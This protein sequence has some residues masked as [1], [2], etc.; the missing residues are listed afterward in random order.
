[1][2][3]IAAP[4]TYSSYSGLGRLR[5]IWPAVLLFVCM[6][7]PPEVA[8]YAGPLRVGVYRMCLMA[9]SPIIIFGI[10]N[11]RYKPHIL[12]LAVILI[13]MWLPLSFAVN[14]DWLVGLE[15]GGSQSLD[16]LL[17]YFIARV[18]IRTLADFRNFLICIFPA[19]MFVGLLLAMESLSGQLFVR[20]TAQSIF[21]GTGD[22]GNRLRAEFREGFLR[23]YSVFTHPIHA[24]LFLS[25]FISLYFMNFR[26]GQWRY[27]GFLVGI[28]GFFSLS[29]AALLGI[30]ANFA[31]L[32][33]DWLQQR[34]K[35]LNWALFLTTTTILIATVQLFSQNGVVPVIYRYLTFNAQTGYYRT[36]IWQYAGSEA[37]AHPWFGIGYEEY[38]RPEWMGRASID[39]HYLFMATSYGFVPAFAYFLVSI[40]VIILLGRCASHSLTS[41]S[42]R[43]FL[44]LAASLSVIVIL[45]FTVTFWGAM[46][47]WFNFT[48][49]IGVAL[50]TWSANLSDGKK[51]VRTGLTKTPSA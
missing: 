50:T 15:A 30:A 17:S 31:I 37:L 24:G 1:M 16:M 9:L 34:V 25:S 13:A 5:N 6:L 29:S 28:L 38:T 42:R 40:I 21:G 8:V 43:A 41:V 36:L 11:G 33:Y 3:S 46:L 19:I 47:S 44:G 51:V 18:T 35:D 48:L 4:A 20:E 49:G 26:G 14:Y 22:V 12:D 10:I 45:M 27:S 7:F 2:A 23:A 32:F 39:A